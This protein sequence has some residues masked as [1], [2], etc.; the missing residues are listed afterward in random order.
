MKSLKELLTEIPH[1]WNGAGNFSAKVSGVQS[2]SRKIKQGDV[3]VA[4]S[5]FQQDGHMFAAEAVKKG[6]QAVVLEHVDSSLD[7]SIPQIL[8]SNTRSV[9]P[10]LVASS[11]DFPQRKIKCIGVTGTNGKTTTT[12]LIQYLLNCVRKAGLVG[13]VHYDDTQAKSSAD[14]TT[15]VPEVFF[16]LLSKM[17]QNGASYCVMEVSSHALDQ[18]RTAGLDFSSAVFTNLT[19]D[20]L[21]YHHDFE[22]YFAAKRKLF[23]GGHNPKHSL[24]NGDDEYGRRLFGELKGKKDVSL[25][26]MGDTVDFRADQIQMTLSS[27]D[28]DFVYGK[29]L[30]PVKASLTLKHN[31][32]NLLAALSTVAKEGFD[33]RELVSHLSRFEGVCGRMERIHEGQDFYLFVDYAHTPDGL[34]NVLSSIQSFEKNRVI[35]VFGCG[36]DRDRTKRPLM[37]EIANKFSD[38]VILTTD[39]PRTEKPEDILSEIKAGI[40]ETKADVIVCLDREAAIAQVI[41]MAQPKDLVFIFGKGHENYQVIGR[42]KIPFSDQTIARNYLR[43]TCSHSKKSQPL[44]AGN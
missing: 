36:G 4:V 31:I 6:A 40:K 33:V 43:K 23:I 22:T 18:D 19:Q 10:L 35:S 3:F 34:F 26:G 30:V 1:S 42:D 16:Q 15:P 25:Y 27:L 2:D 32:Y 20:H 9:L 21:D 44:P 8:V 41:D 39:N 24:M 11:Y 17:V 13:S 14:T 12:F 29:N 7:L 5:G 38:V 28:F 37:G